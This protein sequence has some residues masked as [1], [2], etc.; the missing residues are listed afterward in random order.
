MTEHIQAYIYR[1]KIKIFQSFKSQSL[2]LFDSRNNQI[3][4]EALQNTSISLW[5]E[6]IS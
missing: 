4:I 3:A 2:K 1:N 5:M 6:A